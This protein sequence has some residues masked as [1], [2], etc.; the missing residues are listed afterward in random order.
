M[1]ETAI[2]SK[3]LNSMTASKE[4]RVTSVTILNKEKT[5]EKRGCRCKCKMCREH[6]SIADRSDAVY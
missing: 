3:S 1:Q 6:V 2:I 5:K 4:N